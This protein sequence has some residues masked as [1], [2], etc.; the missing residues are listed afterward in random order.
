MLIFSVSSNSSLCAAEVSTHRSVVE[1]APGGPEQALQYCCFLAFESEQNNYRRANR[2]P[3]PMT[4]SN[5]SIS[6]TEVRLGQGAQTDQCLWG[7]VKGLVAY[8]TSLFFIIPHSEL[9]FHHFEKGPYKCFLFSGLLA[10]PDFLLH[11]VPTSPSVKEDN[12]SE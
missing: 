2:V 10:H 5:V 9:L 12:R 1:I 6:L 4:P 11:L 3:Q 8:S 7:K